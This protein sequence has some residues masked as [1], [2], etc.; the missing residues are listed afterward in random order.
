MCH[1]G[2]LKAKPDNT[3]EIIIVVE[4]AIDI[5]NDNK[6]FKALNDTANLS[7]NTI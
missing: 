3:K 1:D 2:G 5:T 6:A 7:I 4:R